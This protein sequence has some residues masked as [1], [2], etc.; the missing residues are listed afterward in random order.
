MLDLAAIVPDVDPKANHPTPSL[1]VQVRDVVPLLVSVMDVVV[2]VLP[3]ST[4]SGEATNVEDTVIETG[5]FADPAVP[6]EKVM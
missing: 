5:T 6:A 3:K 4:S 1:A 2:A